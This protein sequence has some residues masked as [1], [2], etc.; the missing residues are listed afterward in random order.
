MNS[1]VCAHCSEVPLF[2]TVLFSVIH[3]EFVGAGV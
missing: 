1:S 3:D 2:G